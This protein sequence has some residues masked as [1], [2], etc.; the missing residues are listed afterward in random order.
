MPPEVSKS[1][2]NNSIFIMVN[3]NISSSGEKKKQHKSHHLHK[4]N[5]YFINTVVLS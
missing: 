2:V 4:C 3:I 1:T 5:E